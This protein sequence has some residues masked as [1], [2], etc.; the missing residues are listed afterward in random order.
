MR[1]A[2]AWLQENAEAFGGDPSSVTIWGESSGSFAVVSFHSDWEAS[3]SRQQGQL[4]LSYGGRS[5]GLFHRSI[6]D[7]GSA[8][9]AWYNG[10][11]WY[12]PIYDRIVRFPL[13]S[14]P[15]PANRDQVEKVNCTEAI[16]T[17]ECLRSVPFEDLLPYVN[18]SAVV[19]PGWYPTVDGDIIPEFPTKLLESGRFA[20]VPHLY[21]SNSDEGTDNAPPGVINTD[22]DLYNYLLTGNGFGYTASA[23]QE[24]MELYPD[25]PAQGKWTDTVIVER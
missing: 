21:G 3:N 2:L 9:T 11:E 15:S 8:T 7:S 22:Q 20:K 14:G 4:L 13:V 10:T 18:S 19:G 23:V 25:D 16:D 24:I 6:Q 1:Q 12:Q 17:L 5:D